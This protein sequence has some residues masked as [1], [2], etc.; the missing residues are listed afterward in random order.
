MSKKV[1]I[2]SEPK[3][4][5][6]WAIS[7]QIAKVLKAN[8]IE[9]KLY[10]WGTHN[11]KEDNVLFMGNVFGLTINHMLRFIPDKNIIFYGVTEGVPILTKYNIDIAKNFNLITP[12]Q[13]SKRCLEAAGLEVTAIIPHGID[14]SVKP[15]QKFCEKIKMLLPPQG[16]IK[17]SNIM[18]CIAGNVQ[19]KALD[20]LLVAYKI[21][22]AMQKDSFLI[23]HTGTGDVNISA[24]EH[25]L[26]LKRMLF[27]NSW[28]MLDPPKIAA[29]YKICDYYVQPSMVEGFGLTY[30]EAFRWE[31]PVI[32]VNCPS[33]NEIVKDGHTGILLPVTRQE[34]IIWQQHHSI[35]LHHYDIDDLVQAMLVMSDNNTR[36]VMSNAA[37]KE[38]L[39]WDM[40]D[41]YTKFIPYLQ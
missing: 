18:L 37:K 8:D 10:P 22:Q 12:S 32:G 30:L 39:K 6:F 20:K 3:A 25:A 7:K 36:I 11:I 29:L 19:R 28:G 13:H 2:I 1:A 24:L 38:A 5:S 21:I 26:D 17:P 35:R 15:D 16:N 31:K 14:T 40:N 23:L 34:D 9:A 33:V 4:V 41:I 27:T